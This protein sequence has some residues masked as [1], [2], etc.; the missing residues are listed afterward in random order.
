MSIF[1]KLREESAKKVAAEPDRSPWSMSLPVRALLGDLRPP[2]GDSPD[3][4]RVRALP[5]RPLPDLDGPEGEAFVELA[6]ARWGLGERECRCQ[7]PVDV[8]VGDG[9]Y[10]LGRSYCI[11]RA[12]PIQG[13]A[14]HEISRV[15]GACDPVSTGDGKTWIDIMAAMALPDVKQ[16]VLLIPPGLKGQLKEEYLALNEH[17]RVPSIV[18]SD[19][20]MTHP[21]RPVVHVVSYSILQRPEATDLLRQY[22]PDAIVADEAHRLRNPSTATTRRFLDY[23]VKYPDT[24]FCGWSGTLAARSLKDF[25]HL[26]WLALRKGS[27]LPED[28]A[29]LE[30]WAMSVDPS[31]YPMPAGKLG[32]AFGEPVR[33]G[34][35]QRIMETVG[36]VSSA[37][38]SI[39]TPLHI[40]ERKPPETPAIVEAA[41]RFLRRHK[42]RWDGEDLLEDTEQIT[43]AQQLSCGF[44][45]YWRFPRLA[46]G[47]ETEELI[48]EWFARRQAWNAEVRDR[49]TSARVHL[50]SPKLC[51]EAARRAW[52]LPGHGEPITEYARDGKALPNWR[53]ASYP[54]WLEIEK[55]V[56]PVPDAEWLDDWLAR[57]AA[58]WALEHRGVVW[59]AHD[60]FGRRVAELAGIPLHEG[61]PDAEERIMREIREHKGSRSIVASIKAHGTGRDG[62]QRVFHK[63]LIAN[64]LSSGQQIEQLLGRLSRTG[65]NAPA[66][67]AWSYAHTPEFVTQWENAMA[68][69]TFIN[70]I[71]HKGQ[72]ITTSTFEGLLVA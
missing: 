21:G 16:V 7:V 24:A 49:L 41:L 38:A 35:R 6:S 66:V 44:Y 9:L 29:V 59:Y 47:E 18:F 63:Q 20:G 12:R 52:G 54:A 65:Q 46:T 51:R 43:C 19:W 36:V 55:Q 72:R 69:G 37:G 39:S 61:G 28:F 25:A 48:L 56:H 57:D 68:R 13:W 15:R 40:I 67:Y 23:Y 30:E 1:D 45:Y 71:L 53:A 26:M 3:L 17:F 31:D 8:H 58:A 10:G 64:P 27:P 5:R 14:M 32:E 70:D 60:A 62:L 50:D 2:V 22:A 11:R 33:L 34:L 42:K 4:R